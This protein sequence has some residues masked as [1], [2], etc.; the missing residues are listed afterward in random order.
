MV[1]E[2]RRGLPDR[3]FFVMTERYGFFRNQDRRVVHQRVIHL[4]EEKKGQ[5]RQTFREEKSATDFHWEHG[6][7]RPRTPELHHCPEVDLQSHD[8]G[9]E[10][11]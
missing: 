1:L 5:Q 8:S 11:V 2:P 4:H 10:A 7:D 3:R 9:P 6:L